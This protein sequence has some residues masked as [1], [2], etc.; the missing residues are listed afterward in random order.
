MDFETGLLRISSQE[1]DSSYQE[2]DG[3]WHS[4][5]RIEPHTKTHQDRYIA[6]VP[7]A[8]DILRTL[9][10]IGEFLFM[11]G[12]ERVTSRQ[13]NYILETY[14]SDSRRRT[15]ASRCASAGMELETLRKDL[16]HSSL[17]TTLG[18]I[19]ETDSQKGY[20]IKCSIL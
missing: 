17:T 20:S 9:P 3:T 10:H 7:K 19:Y 6:L 11:R 14:A 8:L 5:Y 4:S 13:V 16:G 15:F 12:T 2:P 18:Y 1:T